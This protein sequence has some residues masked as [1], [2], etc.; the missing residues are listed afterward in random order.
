MSLGADALDARPWRPPPVP[1]SAVDL[2]QFAVWRSADLGPEDILSALALLPAARAEVEGLEAGLL[3]TARSA[4]LTWAQMARRDGVQLPAGVPAA[5]HPPDS[6]TGRRLM[7]RDSAPD[8]LVLH[9]VRITGFADTPVIAHRYGLDAAETKE[10]LRDAEARGWVEHTAFAGTG[11]WS[12]TDRAEPRTSAG[13]RPSSHVSAAPT[14]SVTSTAT[15]LPLNALLL[16]GLHRLATPAHRRRSA[17]RQRPL[18]PAWDAGVLLELA[19]HR[20]RAHATREPARER[21]HPVPRI[22]HTVHHGPGARPSRGGHLGRPHRRRLLPSCLVRA[23]R[24][25]HRHARPRPARGTLT[26]RSAPAGQPTTSYQDQP[27]TDARHTR[28]ARSK[29][30]PTCHTCAPNERSQWWA[31][32]RGIV[33]AARH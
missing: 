33:G 13:S 23:P 24:R 3:F 12:L 22:R 28:G 1:P 8:L 7:T 18:R 25:P 4:G 29:R 19:E 27:F 5:L 20:S 6:T 30:G 9:A 10:M 16:A 11:G 21:P 14:R 26:P 31:R 2:A 32:R 17:R 15:F